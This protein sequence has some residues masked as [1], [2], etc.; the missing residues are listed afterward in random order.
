M[1]CK[2]GSGRIWRIHPYC[3]RAS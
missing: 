3:N 2:W 1:I